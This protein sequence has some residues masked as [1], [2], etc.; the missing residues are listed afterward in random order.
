MATTV[1]KGLLGTDRLH[2]RLEDLKRTK[3]PAPWVEKL[4]VNDQVA[5][6]LI[7]ERGRVL[8]IRRCDQRCTTT[9]RNPGIEERDVCRRVP[10]RLGKD[11]LR[12]QPRGPDPQGGLQRVLHGTM[13]WRS[14]AA[15][16]GMLWQCRC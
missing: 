10:L 7:S 1:L 3:G 14:P 16:D 12:L 4:V 2:A 5:G 13:P 9:E 6:T 11:V 15:S 8:G